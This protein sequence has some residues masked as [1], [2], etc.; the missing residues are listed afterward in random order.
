MFLTKC[1]SLR[2][3]YTGHGDLIDGVRKDQGIEL[4]HGG[5]LTLRKSCLERLQ[6]AVLSAASNSKPIV[7]DCKITDCM[8]IFSLDFNSDASV[9]NCLLGPCDCVLSLSN[10]VSGKVEFRKN[11]MMKG[12]QPVFIID[13]MSTP[14]VHD[15]KRLK[16]RILEEH[17]HA[18]WYTEGPSKKERSDYTKWARE[19]GYNGPD[20]D[21][22]APPDSSDD[23]RYGLEFTAYHKICQKCFRTERAED[24]KMK[25]CKGCEKACYCSRT[26]QINDWPD[27]KLI[28]VNK[29]GKKSRDEEE[30]KS[31][32]KAK[33]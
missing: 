11:K 6:G 4:R 2:G 1:P 20:K 28:C 30:G 22:L 10:N 25:Y 32:R 23:P 13:H 9:E 27:H 8:T 15:F 14:P 24:K 5:Q 31:G 29:K 16:N 12:A 18:R 3:S 17:L 33:R 21:S 26:C 19:V 7:R